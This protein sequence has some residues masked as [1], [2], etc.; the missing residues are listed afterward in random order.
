MIKESLNKKYF[1]FPKDYKEKMYFIIVP[2]NSGKSK[3]L[4]EILNGK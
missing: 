3:A 4:K 1:K 2:R